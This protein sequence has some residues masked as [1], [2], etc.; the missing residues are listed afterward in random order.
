MQDCGR[1]CS[2]G[3]LPVF[4]CRLIFRFISHRSTLLPQILFL[5]SEI[6]RLSELCDD[7]QISAICLRE[8]VSGLRDHLERLHGRVGG[9]RHRV[10]DE[11]ARADQLLTASCRELNYQKRRVLVS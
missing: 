4:S 3:R 2:H 6:A 7:E 1:A 5:E 8:K 10:Q 9:L 11:E